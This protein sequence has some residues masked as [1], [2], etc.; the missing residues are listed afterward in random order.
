MGEGR[1]SPAKGRKNN[2]RTCR[3]RQTHWLIT[4]SHRLSMGVTEPPTDSGDLGRRGMPTKTNKTM[5]FVLVPTQ[6]RAVVRTGRLTKDACVQ[7]GTLMLGI[8]TRAEAEASVGG[9]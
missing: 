1:A 9:A 2:R 8:Y 6:H 3:R 7:C 5:S 4:F